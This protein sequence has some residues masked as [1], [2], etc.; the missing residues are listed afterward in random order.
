[1]GVI[2]CK[3]AILVLNNEINRMR[4]ETEWKSEFRSQGQ[5][6][7]RSHKS[8]YPE[9]SFYRHQKTP[10]KTSSNKNRGLDRKR[11]SEKR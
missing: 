10:L 8:E 5:E 11:K 4:T 7:A 2:I 1:S 6:S 3:K 9:D